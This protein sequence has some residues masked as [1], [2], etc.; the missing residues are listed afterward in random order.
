MPEYARA[1]LR[2][3][4]DL[5]NK[6]PQFED[7]GIFKEL[8]RRGQTRKAAT[9]VVT[10]APK[11]PSQ[12][13]LGDSLIKGVRP[14]KTPKKYAAQSLMMM[15]DEGRRNLSYLEENDE[16]PHV[17]VAEVYD[18]HEARDHHRPGQH[19]RAHA[20]QLLEVAPELVL[21]AGRHVALLRPHP[22]QPRR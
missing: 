20:A 21:G 2:L 16:G 18:G 3:L 22:A 8:T 10:E 19:P 17:D 11:K 1:Q 4:S 15:R 9:I 7:L 12:V 13:F 6:G 14:K 5:S